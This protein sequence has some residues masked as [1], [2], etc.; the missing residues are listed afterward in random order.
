MQLKQKKKSQKNKENLK[1]LAKYSNL[2]FQMLAIILVG[3]F[4]GRKLDGLIN[5]EFP[6]FT[7]ILIPVSVILAIYFAIKD[8]I[9]IK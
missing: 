3:V 7:V 8:L 6:I 9:N 4:G 5:T 1:Y 2:A